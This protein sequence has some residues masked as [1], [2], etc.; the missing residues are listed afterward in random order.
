MLLGYSL[1]L[2]SIGDSILGKMNL[3]QTPL[4]MF[5]GI[6]EDWRNH[7]SLQQNKLFGQIYQKEMESCHLSVPWLVD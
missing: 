5:L 1:C 6:T 4:L 7:F 2:V 3:D